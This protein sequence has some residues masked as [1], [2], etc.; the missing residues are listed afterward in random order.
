MALF[1]DM[2]STELLQFLNQNRNYCQQGIVECIF[3]LK[4]KLIQ[5]IEI[6]LFY[7]L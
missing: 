1:V 7:Q 3:Y 5:I 2:N 4:K 6:Q